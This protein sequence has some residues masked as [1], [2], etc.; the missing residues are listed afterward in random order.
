LSKKNE[1]IVE[2]RIV[3]ERIVK[4]STC[5][6]FFSLIFNYN[7]PLKPM[8]MKGTLEL[9]QT[10]VMNYLKDNFEGNFI[11]SISD[12]ETMVLSAGQVLLIFAI[13]S[14]SLFVS[15]LI[16][17]CE[18]LWFINQQRKIGNSSSATKSK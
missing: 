1:R 4:R 18:C 12:P 17:I 2:E 5:F 10:G 15:F 3:E 8:F 9:F 14:V 13:I 11:P 16:F 6:D 7:S